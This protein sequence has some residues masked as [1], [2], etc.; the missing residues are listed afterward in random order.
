MKNTHFLWD[1]EQLLGKD[2]S[3]AEGVK[4]LPGYIVLA[5]NHVYQTVNWPGI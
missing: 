1:Y 5:E 2:L 4:A 3:S